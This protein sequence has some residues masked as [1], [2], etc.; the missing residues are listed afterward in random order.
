MHEK[1]RGA[2]IICSI[3]LS[4]FLVISRSSPAAAAAEEA[5]A[6][7]EQADSITYTY[8]QKATEMIFV[9]DYSNSMNGNDRDRMALQMLETLVDTVYGEKTKVGLV[10]Y[11]DTVVKAIKPASMTKESARKQLKHTISSI[12]RSGSTDIG[13]A[14][15]TAADMMETSIKKNKNKKN[16]RIILLSDGE[17]DL[18]YSKTGR[19]LEDCYED[20][21]SAAAYCSKNNISIDTIAF[22]SFEG[23]KGYLKALSDETKGL[24]YQAKTA[25]QLVAVFQD[26]IARDTMSSVIPVSASYSSDTSQEGESVRE[27]VLPMKGIPCTEANLLIVSEQPIREADLS[28]MGED[29]SY[30]QAENYFTC[31][32]KNGGNKDITIRVKTSAGQQLTAYA[33]YYND[34]SIKA[35]VPENVKKNIPFQV[36]ISIGDGQN[37]EGISKKTAEAF[38]TPKLVVAAPDKNKTETEFEW[39]ENALITEITPDIT[40]AWKLSLSLKGEIYRL[41]RKTITLEAANIAPTGN[42]ESYI[43]VT[44]LTGEKTFQ[45]DEYFEDGN[46]DVLTYEFIADGDSKPL[47]TLDKDTFTLETEKNGSCTGYFLVT[48]TEGA[49]CQSQTVILECVP[50]WKEYA[51]IL[52]GAGCAAGAVLF[53]GLWIRHKRRN[54]IRKEYKKEQENLDEVEPE[55]SFTGKLNGY[56]T[57]LPDE[58]EIDPFVIPLYQM[59]DKV[60]CLQDILDDMPEIS[61]A[62][63][64]EGI[65][66]KAGRD[67]T[68]VLYHTT[69]CTIMLGNTLVCRKLRYTVEYGDKIYITSP[70]GTMELELHYLSARA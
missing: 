6:A 32:I 4:I 38:F 67:R 36:S 5:A 27:L 34:W 61:T 20:M 39:E 47:Y 31:K 40:G 10:A 49:S 12:P 46:K 53:Y 41:K 17:P 51:G 62:I 70:D 15:K 64:A 29:V 9:V 23:D 69:K 43:K 13:R 30:Y 35:Q 21:D 24:L 3:F 50:L 28:Y 63:L 25:K 18:T 66:I 55:S 16:Y 33:M 45:L 56:F 1:S 68:I 65:F 42:F 58:M 26:V 7:K 2:Y 52:I 11:N 19:S 14:L 22:G 54:A 59:K 8:T 57:R 37:P 44:R 48:D 60:I